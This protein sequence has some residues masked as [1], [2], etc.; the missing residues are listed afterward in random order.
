[1]V[2]VHYFSEKELNEFS[3]IKGAQVMKIQ[4]QLGKYYI[5]HSF[6]IFITGLDKQNI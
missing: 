6:K 2:V 3:K 5:Y 1:M 4:C